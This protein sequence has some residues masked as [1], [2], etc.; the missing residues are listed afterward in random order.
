MWAQIFI[1]R[2]S[3][4]ISCQIVLHV[5][6]SKG[7]SHFFNII[8]QTGFIGQSSLFNAF[9]WEK[10]MSLLQSFFAAQQ[11]C[12]AHRQ[13]LPTHFHIYQHFDLEPIFKVMTKHSILKIGNVFRG[14]L[15][16]YCSNLHYLT[17]ILLG[18]HMAKECSD[19]R[20]YLCS[21]RSWE[22]KTCTIRIHVFWQFWG[23]PR[24]PTKKTEY[25]FT[26]FC[27]LPPY[28]ANFSYRTVHDLDQG[29]E[30]SSHFYTF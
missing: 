3:N 7:F 5:H 28:L 23:F 13:P 26:S 15:F 22:V 4:S 12:L 21:I 11:N 1:L 25:S 16:C 17:W 30:R 14:T 8:L 2:A 18:I 20:W 27:S 6:I 24:E 19:E 9:Y 29:H 10:E